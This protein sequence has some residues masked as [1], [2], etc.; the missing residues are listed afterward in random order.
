L[1]A[2]LTIHGVDW[3]AVHLSGFRNCQFELEIGHRK[4]YY[5]AATYAMYTD[6]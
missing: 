6:I 2:K 4:G 5:F 1:T 3:Q